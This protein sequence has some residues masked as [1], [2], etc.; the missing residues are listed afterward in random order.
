M[1]DINQLAKIAIRTES[2][3]PDLNGQLENLKAALEL[4][5]IAGGILDQVK[6][7][8]FYGEKGDYNHIKLNALVDRLVQIDTFAFTG[9]EM[10]HN[11][12]EQRV[13]VNTRIVHGIVGSVT[14][15]AE[16]AEALVEY[17]NTGAIDAVNL[18]EEIFDSRWYALI[19][20]DELNV[21]DKDGFELLIAKLSARYGDRFSDVAAVIRDIGTE[22]EVM[23]RILRTQTEVQ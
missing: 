9:D 4:V 20:Q 13:D 6:R 14:E 18:V 12:V 22:R 1:T 8:I 10:Q 19:L 11:N 17:L 21:S 3:V 2:V 15:A 7:K 5:A 23:E 16:M